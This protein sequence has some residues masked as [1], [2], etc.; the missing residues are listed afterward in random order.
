[1]QE[2]NDQYQCV[3]PI[4]QS[5]VESLSTTA[6]SAV[7]ERDIAALCDKMATFAHES[8]YDV[9]SQLGDLSRTG[10][11]LLWSAA[12]QANEVRRSDQSST[13]AVAEV[14][15]TLTLR[16]THMAENA[17]AAEDAAIIARTKAA[18]ARKREEDKATKAEED[19]RRE[20]EYTQAWVSLER[21][22]RQDT[23]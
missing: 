13:S 10:A 3:M 22:L 18:N 7:S 21:D 17:R 8:T 23:V 19:T 14:G 9:I 20:E 12:R 15:A 6:R 2:K 1:M 11:T 16:L 5:W 4:V